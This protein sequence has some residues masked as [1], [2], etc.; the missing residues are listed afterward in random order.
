MNS[1]REKRPIESRHLVPEGTREISSNPEHIKISS[2]ESLR[3]GTRRVDKV[4]ERLSE[5]FVLISNYFITRLVNYKMFQ[6]DP[7]QP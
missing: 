1:T 3:F 5:C 6:W 4:D 2:I 7:A